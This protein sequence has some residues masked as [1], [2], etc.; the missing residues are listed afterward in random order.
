MLDTTFHCY[1]SIVE[2]LG[3]KLVMLSE[4]PIKAFF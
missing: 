1:S 4:N 3:H 2:Y